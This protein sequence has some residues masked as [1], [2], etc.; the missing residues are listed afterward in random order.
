MYTEARNN[1]L[2]AAVLD[3]LQYLYYQTRFRRQ[4]LELERVNITLALDPARHAT[5]DQV[6]GMYQA[7]I[8]SREDYAYKVN[9]SSLLD[10][11]ERE[12]GPLTEYQADNEDYGR[13]IEAIRAI[14]YSY[15]PAQTINQG[16]PGDDETVPGPALQTQQ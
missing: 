16:A 2:D 11:F 14:V 8:L 15:I 9:T 4:T 12:N 1:Q 13:R 6:M 7:G 3:N 10:R 5:P